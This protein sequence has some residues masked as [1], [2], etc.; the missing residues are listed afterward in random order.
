MDERKGLFEKG[1]GVMDGE[2]IFGW[3]FGVDG[4]EKGD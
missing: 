1:W 2:W 3:W 4:G